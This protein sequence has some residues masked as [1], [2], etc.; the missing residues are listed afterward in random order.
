MSNTVIYT[1]MSSLISKK[2][3][4][5]KEEVMDKLSVYFAFNMIDTAQMAELAL[6]AEGVY[7]PPV[8][9]PEIPTEPEVPAE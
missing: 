5:T 4:P 3:Y 9:E 7:A 8:T 2:Y 6:L 1:L